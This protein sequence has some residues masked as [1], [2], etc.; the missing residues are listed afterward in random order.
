[1]SGQQI[2]RVWVKSGAP[3]SMSTHGL[4]AQAH[5]RLDPLHGAATSAQLAGHLQNPFAARQRRADCR[6]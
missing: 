4:G 1:M 6:C 2:L 5:R 3:T